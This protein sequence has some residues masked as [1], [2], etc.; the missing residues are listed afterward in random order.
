M[1]H[2]KIN[3]LLKFN[4]SSN[5]AEKSKNN[6]GKKVSNKDIISTK[7]ATKEDTDGDDNLIE[8]T[9]ISGNK[10]NSNSSQRTNKHNVQPRRV[11]I[12]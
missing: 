11:I 5:D 12:F 2:K 4:T 8:I 3:L 6:N 1:N 9:R 7:K 10:E